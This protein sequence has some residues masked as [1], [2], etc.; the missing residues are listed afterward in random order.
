MGRPGQREAGS[1]HNKLLAGNGKLAVKPLIGLS[2]ALALVV[3]LHLVT[4]APKPTLKPSTFGAFLAPAVATRVDYLQRSLPGNRR[5]PA[6]IKVRWVSVMNTHAGLRANFHAE[7]G[8]PANMF[9]NNTG[10]FY[11]QTS[12][13]SWVF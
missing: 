12:P 11:I 1:A 3:P 2:C 5:M 7:A 8:G 6:P 10:T 9:T 4:D 13:R